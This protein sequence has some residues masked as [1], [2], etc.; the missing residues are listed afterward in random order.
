MCLQAGVDISFSTKRLKD[1]HSYR[2]V[3]PGVYF[4]DSIHHQVGTSDCSCSNN[5]SK[6]LQ[7]PVPVQGM[8]PRPLSVVTDTGYQQTHPQDAFSNLHTMDRIPDL[9]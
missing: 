8:D 3:T 5:S 2:I 1:P 6:L 7:G 9:T 4:V